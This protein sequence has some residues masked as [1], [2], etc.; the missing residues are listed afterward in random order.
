[1]ATTVLIPGLLSDERVWRPVADRIAPPVILADVTLDDTIQAMAARTLNAV[2]GPIF[3]VGHSM[4]GRVAME[5]ANQAPDR[6][7]RLVLANTGH[8]PPRPGEA[9]KRQAKINQGH[10]NFPSMVESWLPPMIAA[11]RHRDANLIS[12]LTEMALSVGPIVHERQI[13][14]LMARPDASAYLPH[15][16]CPILLITGTEDGWSPEIQHREIQGM[17]PN[18]ELHVIENAGYF[19][20]VEQP[21]FVAELIAGWLQKEEETFNE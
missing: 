12:N 14:A 18:A 20:P 10:A 6:V 1:M 9:G 4:G 13:K 2:S 19:L 21:D 5:L 11:S 7:E 16:N 8:H 15:L 17:A 3:A